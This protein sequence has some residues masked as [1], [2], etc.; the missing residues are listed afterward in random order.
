[1]LKKVHQ[2]GHLS[3][4]GA[5]D[6]LPIFTLGSTRLPK[7]HPTVPKVVPR[8]ERVTQIDPKCG[9]RISKYS[10]KAFPKGGFPL[11][12]IHTHTCSDKGDR[13][14]SQRTMA[15]DRKHT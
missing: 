11:R 15:H 13:K 10:T 5:P 12:Y 1:M 14:A 4:P 3:W 6:E 8:V 9:P 2:I 7:W